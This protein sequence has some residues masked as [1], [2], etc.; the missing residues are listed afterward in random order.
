[1]RQNNLARQNSGQ[2]LVAILIFTTVA[3]L[4][5]G[6]FASWS[7]TNLRTIKRQIAKEEAFAIAEAGIEYYRWHLAHAPND[8]TDG[9][10]SSGP[11]VHTF[12]DKN[13]N[14]VGKFYLEI[15]PP[16]TG[17][18]VVT[19]RSTG[20]SFTDPL[21]KRTIETKLAIPSWAKFATVANDFMRFGGG[22]EVFGPIHSNKGIRF[23]GIA[24]NIVT[25][26]VATFD[27]PDHGG[28]EEFGVHTHVNPID[29][30][31]PAT[32]PNRPDVFRAGRQ[33]PVA[34]IDFV[35]ITADLSAIRNGAITGGRRFTHSGAL[36]YRILLKTNDTFDLYKV[37]QLMSAPSGCTNILNQDGWGT[38]SIRTQGGAESFLGNYTFPAN[39][40]IFVEDNVWVE[41]KIDSARLTIASGRFPDQTS[42]RTSITINKDLAY[43]NYDGR[44]A[45]ALIAQKN[46][47][48]GMNSEND[49]I[50]D[51]A[52][53]A[54]NGRVG[55]YY[56]APPSWFTNRC[57]PYHT[58]SRV[59]LFGM[60]GTNERYGFAY[61]DGTGYQDRIITYDANLLYAP[62]PSFPLTSDQYSVISWKEI[63]D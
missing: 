18:T 25:S 21:A 36:G 59:R 58:R 4:F 32:V 28:A 37:N 11:Y 35:G 6:A 34:N 62:P 17:S 30:L 7:I 20:E 1:M 63:K 51:A 24:H 54:Q 23:D 10:N 22:T 61:T 3:T 45:I 29:P 49:L 50:I 31:P 40:L 38:W 52:L 12:Y 48:I 26:G 60:I 14:A 27:D 55:R 13:A 57:S 53:I 44:D 2:I 47:N 56:Y 46:I 33:F 43:T 15:T 19:I 16:P 8:F 42:T 9:T 41:G 39:G 5:I